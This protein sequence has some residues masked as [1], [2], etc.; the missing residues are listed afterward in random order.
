MIPRYTRPAMAAIWEPASRFRIW[1]EIEFYACE[2]LADLGAI[3]GRHG[4][5][6]VAS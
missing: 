6:R 4:C 3:P 5:S 2:A 1:F